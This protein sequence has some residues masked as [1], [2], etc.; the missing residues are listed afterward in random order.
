V[1]RIGV[2]VLD[3]MRSGV[4]GVS[5]GPQA[6]GGVE[7]RINA[8][9]INAKTSDHA[10]PTGPCACRDAEDCRSRRDQR[11]LRVQA[12]RVLGGVLGTEDSGGNR[13][14]RR[15]RS[16]TSDVHPGPTGQLTLVYNV[17]Y[18]WK[19]SLSREE[20]GLDEADLPTE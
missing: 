11:V 15:S 4:V 5:A 1:A 20:A 16:C 17:R 12:E 14:R 8:R 9:R 10:G 3:E 7:R 2:R 19:L 18:Y 6:R 13:D